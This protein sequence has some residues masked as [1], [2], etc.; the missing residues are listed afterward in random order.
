MDSENRSVLS[1]RMFCVANAAAARLLWLDLLLVIHLVPPLNGL[2]IVGH[3]P[4][5]RSSR[6]CDAYILKSEK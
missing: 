6:K 3:F 5:R 2:L 1:E 4:R